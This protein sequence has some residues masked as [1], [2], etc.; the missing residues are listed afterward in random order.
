MQPGFYVQREGASS[1][2]KL[3]PMT[4]QTARFYAGHLAGIT[5]GTYH[6]IEVRSIYSTDAKPQ[7]QRAARKRRL[8]FNA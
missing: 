3:D 8:P 7:P 5:G 6:V 1:P 4:K 2:V